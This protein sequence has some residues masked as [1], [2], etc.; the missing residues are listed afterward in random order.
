[1]LRRAQYER[2]FRQQ[3]LSNTLQKTDKGI[4]ILEA[5]HYA[6]TFAVTP[7]EFRPYIRYSIN[8][9]A[10]A[11][12]CTQDWKVHEENCKRTILERAAKLRQRRT[13]V[14][15]GS[16]L[17]RDVPVRELCRLFDTVVLID[18]VH[19]ASVKL[20]QSF[21]QLKNL[22]FVYRDLSGYEDAAEDRPGEPLGFLRLVPYLDFVVSAN[23]LSQIGTGARDRLSKHGLETREQDVLPRLIKA[24]VEGLENLPCAVCLLTDTDYTVIDRNGNTHETVDLLYGVETPT[25]VSDWVWPVVPLG[26]ES[27]DYKVVHKVIAVDVR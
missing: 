23:V 7:R 26:E 19:P 20:E 9:W 1:V 10:R 11:K 25:P 12:R 27:R 3:T 21:R 2:G 14:V 4:M 5:I 15:L 17:W 13:A 24:H 8:L 18:L 22:R 6:A 16:G